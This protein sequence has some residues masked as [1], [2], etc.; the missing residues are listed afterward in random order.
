MTQNYNLVL[1]NYTSLTG[2]TPVPDPN[3]PVVTVTTRDPNIQTPTPATT[4][5]DRLDQCVALGQ[6]DGVAH[7]YSDESSN[8]LFL[9]RNWI[10]INAANEWMSFITSVNDPARIDYKLYT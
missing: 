1:K 6:T 3:F 10:D 4:F 7:V 8:R 2:T 9:Y 5:E